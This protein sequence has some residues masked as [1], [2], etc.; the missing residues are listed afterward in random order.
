MD[1]MHFAVLRRQDGFQALSENKI[2]RTAEEYLVD[3]STV[4]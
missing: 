1:G 4:A 2:Y 3:K